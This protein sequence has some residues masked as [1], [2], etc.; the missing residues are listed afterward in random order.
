MFVFYTE[1][2]KR[3]FLDQGKVIV[4]EVSSEGATPFFYYIY[5]SGLLV[6]PPS[7]EFHSKLL[8]YILFY[9]IVFYMIIALIP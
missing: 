5:I 3:N 8:C 9:I 2:H 1:I 4:F 7:R 6:F